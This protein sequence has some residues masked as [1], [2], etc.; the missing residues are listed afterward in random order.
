MRPPVVPAWRR[1]LRPYL[2][3]VPAVAIVVGILYP[4]VLG[5]YYSFL[6]Y[7]AIEPDAAFVGLD[8]FRIVLTSSEFWDSVQVTLVFAV[9]GHRR[10]RPC[11][12]SE[13]PCCSTGPAS[14]ARSSRRY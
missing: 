3:S 8:N 5:A 4:F 11:S 12:A 6:N 13:S 10:S 14:S 2:L 7:A 9:A 1:K